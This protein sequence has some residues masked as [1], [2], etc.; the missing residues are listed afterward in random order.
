MSSIE[1]EIGQI[2]KDAGADSRT[3]PGWQTLPPVAT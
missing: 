3:G 2:A 1:A